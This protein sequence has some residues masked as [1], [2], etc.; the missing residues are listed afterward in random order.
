MSDD[1]RSAMNY[2]C[3][4]GIEEACRLHLENAK[5]KAEISIW[6]KRF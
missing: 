5:L 6:Q 2:T 4:C 3:D 1:E